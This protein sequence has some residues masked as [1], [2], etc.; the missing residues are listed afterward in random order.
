[1]KHWEHLSDFGPYG[2]TGG[3]WECP[4]LTEVPVESSRPPRTRWVLKVGLNPGGLQGGSGEQY[5]VGSFDSTRFV[6]DK[7]VHHNP[8]DRLWQGLLLRPDFQPSA[9]HGIACHAR[10]DEQL[11]VRQ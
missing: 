10:L 4:T 2:A 9:T 8:L 7:S 3:Q 1:M 5:F 6:N 11:A